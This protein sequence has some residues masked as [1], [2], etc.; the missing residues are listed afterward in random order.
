MMQQ[1]IRESVNDSLGIENIDSVAIK[2]Q[3]ILDEDAE[4]K[5]TDEDIDLNQ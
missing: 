4:N 2:I 1:R 5:N 3:E